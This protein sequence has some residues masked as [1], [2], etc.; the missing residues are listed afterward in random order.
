MQYMF[1]DTDIAAQRLKVLAD[2]YAA[3]TQVFLDDV[4]TF[5]PEC[6]V[7]LGCGPGHTTHLLA[8]ALDG[9]RVVGF[10]KSEHFIALAEQTQTA[11]VMF[12]LHDVTVVPFPTQAADLLYARL[13]L[14]HLR[15]PQGVLAAWATQLRPKGCLLLEEV[16]WIHTN[17]FLFTTYLDMVTAL[18]ADQATHMYAGQDLH[19][20]ADPEVVTQACESSAACTGA[21]VSSRHHVFPEPA[22][23]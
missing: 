15:D 21:N 17:S 14:A 13:L 20:L 10:D 23:V 7:D 8:K 19:G 11:K 2:V 12:R 9:D 3:S 18:L 16:E 1:G 5:R 4:M 6:I 22:N